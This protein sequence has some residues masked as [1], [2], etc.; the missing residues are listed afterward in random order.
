[1]LEP[2][3]KVYR[4][5]GF[6]LDAGSGRLLGR[7]DQVIPIPPKSLE[8]L[9][10][11]VE[12][13]GE[14]VT[15][16]DLLHG[17]WGSE[18]VEENNLTV[19]IAALRKALGEKKGDNDFIQTV[20]GKG[21]RFV[22]KVTTGT[23]NEPSHQDHHAVSLA[24]LP[25]VNEGSDADLEYLCDGITESIIN[26]LSQS[27]R[28]RVLSRNAV[29]LHKN[30]G[31][32]LEKIGLELGVK[33]ALIGRLRLAE[34]QLLLSVELVNIEDRSQIWGARFHHTLSNL[35]EL[36]EIIAA[37][38]VAGLRLKLSDGDKAS[39][40]KRQT[41]NGDAYLLYLKGRYFWN[42]RGVSDLEKAITYFE[43]AI[44]T[45]PNYAE[46]YAG[47]ADCYCQIASFGFVPLRQIVS[48]AEAAVAKAFE[49]DE[50]LAEAYTSSAYLSV[51]FHRN[52][53]KGETDHRRAIEL[54]PGYTQA[55]IWLA[56]FLAKMGRFDEALF[57]IGKARKLE[58]LSVPLNRVFARILYLA[59]R[60]DEAIKKCEEILELSPEFGLSNGILGVIYRDKGM[61]D[62]ALLEINKLIEFSAGE[63]LSPSPGDDPVF[64]SDR[65]DRLVFSPS[66]PEAT[67]VAGQIYALKGDKA[68]ALEV[69]EWLNDLSAHRYVE[70]HATALVY[71]GL[72]DNDKAF[73]FLE[74]SFA[75]SSAVLTY[76]NVWSLLDPL[77]PDPRFDQLLRR[78]GFHTPQ[79]QAVRPLG[80][81]SNH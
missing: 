48:K 54:N 73:E 17:I 39:F 62:E 8:L 18:S 22:A 35:L 21:Y 77:R 79:P 4:F 51:N 27:N 30:K 70:P 11:L 24:V 80:S 42:S 32:D 2:E 49:L 36:Q 7:D 37:E 44:Q 81:L 9:S 23:E 53:L 41:S 64:P 20:Q 12:N 50:N 63:Y 26:K 10:F 5:G 74:K 46:A 13:H 75:D 6:R 60:Y 72:G 19:R 52:W 3:I 59:R 31:T 76:F 29:F 38:V 66:D 1:M 65:Y 28:L 34:N 14:L 57:Q 16:D 68:K 56:N 45:D 33:T 58:P 61:Y 40:A 47:L 55:Y 43:R 25:I 78:I 71:A 69:I 15:K 67:G